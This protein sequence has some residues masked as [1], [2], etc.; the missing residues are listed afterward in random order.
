MA[1]MEQLAEYLAEYTGSFYDPQQV[2]KY[3]K[4]IIITVLPLD[5]SK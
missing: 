3:M 5:E 2:Q 4:I 1:S